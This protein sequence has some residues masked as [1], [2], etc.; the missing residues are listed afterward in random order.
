MSADA[1]VL[2]DNIR[3]CAELFQAYTRGLSKD[4]F[5][6]SSQIQDAVLRRIEII[7]EAV[8]ACHKRSRMPIPIFH[9]G[10]WGAC[11]T[12]FFIAISVW[13]LI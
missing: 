9:G 5:L 13:T 3:E 12:F 1:R 10:R 8:K 4:E 2:L 11:E 6:A 7:G